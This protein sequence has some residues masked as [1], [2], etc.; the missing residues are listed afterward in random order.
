VGQ[1]KGAG[2][3]KEGHGCS[4]EGRWSQA[5]ECRYAEETV[6]DDEGTVGGEEESGVV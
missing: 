2:R 6:R 1:E 4:E 3:G 5:D